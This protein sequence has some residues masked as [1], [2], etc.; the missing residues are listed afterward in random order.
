MNLIPKQQGKKQCVVQADNKNEHTN[1]D[2]YDSVAEQMGVEMSGVTLRRLLEVDKFEKE[3]PENTLQLLSKLQD[4]EISIN[5]AYKVAKKYPT[6]KS[7]IESLVDITNEIHK[8]NIEGFNVYHK[9][10]E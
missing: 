4:R 10:C 1:V 8:T 3:F 7:E 6:V 9:S 5:N 2:R